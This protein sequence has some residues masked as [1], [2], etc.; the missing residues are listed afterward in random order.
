F[1][2]CFKI[3]DAA[4]VSFNKPV[5][6]T[7]FVQFFDVCRYLEHDGPVWDAVVPLHFC[8]YRAFDTLHAELV[9]RVAEF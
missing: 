2:K 8:L 1:Q 5:C 6:F 3:P 7:F 9:L 4:L